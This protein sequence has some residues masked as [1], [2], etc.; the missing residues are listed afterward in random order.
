VSAPQR[1][2]PPPPHSVL[3]PV[4]PGQADAAVLTLAHLLDATPLAP[5][6]GIAVTLTGALDRRLREA[7]APWHPR[8]RHRQRLTDPRPVRACG[9]TLVLRPGVIPPVDLIARLSALHPWPARPVAL[10]CV[11]LPAGAVAAPGCFGTA[12]RSLRDLP[13][14]APEAPVGAVLLPDGALGDA[15]PVDRIARPGLAVAGT[16]APT[17][18]AGGTTLDDLAGLH[19]GRPAVVLGNGPSLARLDLSALCDPAGVIFT[20]NG[21]WRLH[22]AGRL[23]PRADRW[24]VVEDRRVATEEG[25]ALAALPGVPL[26]LPTDHADRIAPGP[27]RLHVPVDWSWYAPG[28]RRPAPGF[29]TRP[30]GPLHA[31]QSVAYLALQ[32]AFLMGCD[33]V[34]LVGVDLDYRL[35]VSARVTGRVV[36]SAGPDPNHFDAG[37]FGPGRTWHLPKPDRMLAA[38]RHAAAVY[39]AHGRRLVNAAP[40][41]TG[42]RLSGLTRR[43]PPTP[44]V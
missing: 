11:P 13:A 31:G 4:R 35:P 24:H 23:D 40:S 42:G 9:P 33:P 15:A 32:L 22:R 3:I 26:V 36:T 30:D 44:S 43:P 39:A 10:G 25:A 2:P 28:D 17:M 34:A 12:V 14:P 16:P 5:G 6:P 7:L 38:F 1:E 41:G 8:V 29:A 27:G 18:P 21:A 19:A 37:Y 20:A